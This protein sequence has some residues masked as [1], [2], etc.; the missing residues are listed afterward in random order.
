MSG[1]LFEVAFGA[2]SPRPLFHR[3]RFIITV[4]AKQGSSASPLFCLASPLFARFTYRQKRKGEA[5]KA[6]ASPLHK[7]LF[8][9]ARRKPD[10]EVFDGQLAGDEAW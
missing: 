5:G 7:T 9:H 3:Y 6:F 1:F 8:L 10:V 2:G 4:G